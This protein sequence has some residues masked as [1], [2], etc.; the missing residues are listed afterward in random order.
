[1]RDT[2]AELRYFL[3]G[4]ANYLC[5]VAW[6][7]HD[8]GPTCEFVQNVLGLPAW[9]PDHVVFGGTEKAV[10]QRSFVAGDDVFISVCS[11]LGEQSV[12]LN[13]WLDGR[14]EGGAHHVTLAVDDVAAMRARFEA[15]GIV[16]TDLDQERLPAEQRRPVF[17][18]N[19]LGTQFVLLEPPYLETRYPD[20]PRGPR[21][22]HGARPE[23]AATL[24]E[25]ELTCADH[26]EV[27]AFFEGVLGYKLYGL[28]NLMS[29]T[30]YAALHLAYA[31]GPDTFFMVN[32]P[33]P[34][35][36]AERVDRGIEHCGISTPD[37]EELVRRAAAAGLPPWTI[38]FDAL[39]KEQHRLLALFTVPGVSGSPAAL[40]AQAPPYM[41]GRY[42]YAYGTDPARS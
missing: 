2:D 22:W 18:A 39:P 30:P 33:P 26:R 7:V 17:Y 14:E 5:E 19:A 4:H 24:G 23:P 3:H 36:D 21:D 32:T 1:M 41:D 27:R 10:L 34:G 42:R 9:G 25:C 13:A 16:V 37:V 8:P 40:Q 11:S 35:S 31:T 38:P 15:A 28:H 6:Y 12:E 20:L 29:D